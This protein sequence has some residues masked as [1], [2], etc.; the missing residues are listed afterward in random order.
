MI[1]WSQAFQ[2]GRRKKTLVCL[3]RNSTLFCRAIGAV[4]IEWELA[5]DD[6]VSSF[7]TINRSVETVD[8]TNAF[9]I[10]FIAF[11]FSSVL[12]TDILPFGRNHPVILSRLTIVQISDQRWQS[13]SLKAS[14]S[15]NPT[16]RQKHYVAIR[17]D[18]KQNTN[19]TPIRLQR[20]GCCWFVGSIEWLLL[21]DANCH[22]CSLPQAFAMKYNNNTQLYL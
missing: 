22:L 2:S 14:T 4:T 8:V 9:L 20:N 19:T 1:V 3:V 12:E 15:N 11:W 18:R 16:N 13:E 5:S 10:R 7:W 21:R 6:D 17:S